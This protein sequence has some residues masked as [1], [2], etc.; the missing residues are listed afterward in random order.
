LSTAETACHS[1][2]E[3]TGLRVENLSFD[4]IPQQSRLFLDYLT[5]PS[6]LRN[7][8]PEA[9]KHHYDL[10]QRGERVHPARG[11][12]ERQRLPAVGGPVQEERSVAVLAGRLV[13]E[14]RNEPDDRRRSR[15]R[16]GGAGH[17]ANDGNARR[18]VR[19]RRRCDARA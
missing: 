18:G 11:L 8:Y 12:H 2:P 4:R 1:T 7:F 15:R 17:D 16:P 5:D 3:Q 19:Q 13:G 14:L 9:V 6:K 10:P